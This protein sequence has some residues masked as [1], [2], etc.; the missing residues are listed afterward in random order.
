MNE[1]QSAEHA[2]AY[3]QRADQVPHRAAGEAVL[4]EELPPAARRV[5]DLGA[6]DGRLLALVLLA[7]PAARGVA[8]D[9][10]PPMLARLRERFAA[11]PRVEVVEHDLDDPLPDRGRFDA[12]VSSFAIHHLAHDRKRRLYEEV[13]AVLEPGGVFG[14]LEHVASPTPQVH[15]RFLDAMGITAEEEDPSNKLLDVETQLGWLRQIG[16]T[17]VDCHWK[18]R[19][20]ALLVGSKPS[21]RFL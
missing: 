2:L 11:D 8:L 15:Q 3:L 6:G 9:F 4:L 20:L 21:T 1:W 7:R 5:L 17:D 10:S 14:N 16:F 19:E 18:W 13:W 12:V